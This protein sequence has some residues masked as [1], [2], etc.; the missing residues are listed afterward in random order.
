MALSSPIMELDA[1]CG[2]CN[3]PLRARV[4]YSHGTPTRR[5][6]GTLHMRCPCGAI[7]DSSACDDPRYGRGTKAF[8][9]AVGTIV[10][11]RI[12]QLVEGHRRAAAGGEG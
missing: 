11:R 5:G 1:K 10:H 7:N 6:G 8:W 9:G 12:E 2:R 3:M 4:Q